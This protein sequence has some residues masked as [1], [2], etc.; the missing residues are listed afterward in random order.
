MTTENSK[1]PVE[2]PLWQPQWKKP[3]VNAV[4]KP[5]WDDDGIYSY[6]KMSKPPEPLWQPQW[7][8]PV[9]NVDRKH[10]Q[11]YNFD[12]S[13]SVLACNIYHAD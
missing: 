10:G 11:D 2:E 13:W 6:L 8:K 4:K 12:P 5:A 3:V 7:K 1:H 9:V